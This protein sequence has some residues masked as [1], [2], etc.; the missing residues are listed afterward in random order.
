MAASE[1]RRDEF[2][3]KGPLPDEVLEPFDAAAEASLEDQSRLEATSD[4]SF[5]DF[6]A[7][8]YA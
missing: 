8:Y 7:E 2:L 3:A 6:L 4:L 1:Q 5:S